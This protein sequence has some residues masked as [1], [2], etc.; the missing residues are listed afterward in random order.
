MLFSFRKHIVRNELLWK[1]EWGAAS[2]FCS[3]RANNSRGVAILI[4]TN[5]DCSV[6]EIVTDADGRYIKLKVLLKGERGISVT[7]NTYGPNR[8]N[9][10]VIIIQFSE[11]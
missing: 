1:R 8:D 3:H 5:F 7:V 4:L 11:V 6:E 2:F 10:L 9:K